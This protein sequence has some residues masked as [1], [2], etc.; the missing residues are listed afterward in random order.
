MAKT[1]EVVTE[2]QP[3][4]EVSEAEPEPEPEAEP[5]PEPEPEAEVE[6]GELR[7][8]RHL[9]PN[10]IELDG[11]DFSLLIVNGGTSRGVEPADVI[12][13]V[14]SKS[15]LTGS[16]IRRVRVLSRYTLM[17]VP[18]DKAASVAGAID[19][20][21]LRGQTVAADAVVAETS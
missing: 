13:L 19:G 9:K 11:D 18:S 4:A 6:R 12:E 1:E 17:Q 20:A 8:P 2:D 15:D 16:D 21:Q 3:E 10:Q 14:T 5:E 7:H